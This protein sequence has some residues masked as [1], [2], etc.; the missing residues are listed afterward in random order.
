MSELTAVTY[1]FFITDENR[2][3]EVLK[4]VYFDVGSECVTHHEGTKQN[5]S[6]IPYEV[7]PDNAD[8]FIY[9]WEWLHERFSDCLKLVVVSY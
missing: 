5:F 6:V 2:V 4:Q 1:K 9:G 8:E 7:E 3:S